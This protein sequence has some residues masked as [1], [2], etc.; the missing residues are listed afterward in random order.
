MHLFLLFSAA[1]DSGNAEEAR[2]LYDAMSEAGRSVV[3]APD[4][5]RPRDLRIWDPDESKG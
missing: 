3:D 2:R 5:L 4:P 1:V